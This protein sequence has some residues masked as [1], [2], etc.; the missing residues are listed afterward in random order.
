MLEIYSR[1][2]FLFWV[3]TQNQILIFSRRLMK[4]SVGSEFVFEVLI[5]SS[6]SHGDSDHQLLSLCVFIDFLFFFSVASCLTSCL[7]PAS[8]WQLRW[9]PVRTL[10]RRSVRFCVRDVQR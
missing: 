7:M 6:V 1:F 2:S 9:F 10:Q 8:L 5:V 3:Q 4:V